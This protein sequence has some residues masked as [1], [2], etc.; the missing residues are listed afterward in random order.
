MIPN[1][2]AKVKFKGSLGSLLGIGKRLI[3]P[4]ESIRTSLWPGD[5]SEVTSSVSSTLPFSSLDKD[6]MEGLAS[7]N[8]EFPSAVAYFGVGA[9]LETICGLQSLSNEWAREMDVPT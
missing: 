4:E 5:T 7:Y 1:F 3:S 6:M 9:S 8:F 2:A